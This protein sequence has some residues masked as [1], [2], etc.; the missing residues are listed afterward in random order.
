MRRVKING[1]CRGNMK[2]TDMIKKRANKFN[3]A[4]TTV[5][6]KKFDSK[7]E[8]AYYTHLKTLKRIGDVEYFLMQVP[9]VLLGGKKYVCDFL[10]FYTDGRI[11]Y[12]DVKGR[13]TELFKLKKSIV[14][15]QYPIKIKVL[16]KG[17][18]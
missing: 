7:L 6:N 16:K 15:A 10:V 12:V 2:L 5:D 3:A 11:E 13:E 9:I 4:A 8:A 14:E 1:A 17:D 18:F